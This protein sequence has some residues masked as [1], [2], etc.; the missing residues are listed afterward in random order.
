MPTPILHVK[1]KCGSK[2]FDLKALPDTGASR[3]ILAYDI[4][5]KF[6]LPLIEQTE[7]I[8]AANG[9]PLKCEG[10]VCLHLSFNNTDVILYPLVSSDLHYD[11][12]LSWHDLVLIGVIHSD[13]PYVKS[14]FT[15]VSA[16]YTLPDEL[17]PVLDEFQDVFGDFDGEVLKPMKGPPMSIQLRTDMPIHPIRVTTA[18]Q[19]PLHLREE[20][21]AIVEKCV[22]SGI[23]RKIDQVTP[24][25]SPAFFI[26]DPDRGTGKGKVRLV[27]DFSHLNRYVHRPIH[28]FPSS[29]DIIN[30]I[31]ADSRVFAKLDSLKGYWTIPLDEEAQLLTTILLPSGKYAHCRA[32]MGLNASNDEYCRRSDE[33]IHGIPGALK[34][35]DD[36]MLQAPNMTI[37]LERLRLYLQKCR[38]LGI[39]ISKPKLEIGPEIKFAGH[40]VSAEGVKPDPMKLSAIRDFPTPTDI[41]DLRSFLGLANQ[42]TIFHPDLAQ[43]T[44]LLR[45]LLRKNI[46]FQWLDE[47]EQCFRKVKEVLTSP[48]IVRYF[49]PKLPTELLTDASRLKGLGYA[50][51]QRDENNE[52]RLISCGSKSLTSAEK[53]YATIELECL[54]IVHAI[55]KCKHQLYGIDSFQV[56]TDHKPLVGIFQKRLDEVENNR[57]QRFREKLLDYNFVVAWT[58]GKLHLIADALSRNPVF[59]HEYDVNTNNSSSFAINIVSEDPCL[60]RLTMLAQQDDEYQK[61]IKLFKSHV[62]PKTLKSHP[63]KV[64]SSIWDDI[65]FNAD[66]GL[67]IYNDRRIIVPSNARDSILKILHLSHQGVNKTLM[68]IC[69]LYYW[70]SMSHNVHLLI[71]ACPQ[72]QMHRPAQPNQPLQPD[73]AIRPMQK[74]SC[75]LYHWDN[76]NYLIAVD[77]YSGYPFTSPLRQLHTT[78]VT[79]CLDNWFLVYGYPEVVKSDGGPQFRTEFAQYCEEH[80]MHHDISSAYHSQS[81]G[82]AEAGVRNVKHLIKKCSGFNQDFLTALQSFRNSVRPQDGFSPN[83]MF[84]GRRIRDALPCLPTSLDPVDQPSA[85][86]ARQAAVAKYKHAYDKHAHPLS[87]LAIG[88]YVLVQNP[89]SKLWDSTATVVGTRRHHRSYVLSYPDDSTNVRNRKFLKP[90]SGEFFHNA[91]HDVQRPESP[92]ATPHCSLRLRG[93]DPI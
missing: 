86:Q 16:S 27:T 74:V 90:V 80:F 5:Q 9:T 91:N 6:N 20:A 7:L 11:A 51:I 30:S 49:N 28:P 14:S 58:P 23:L 60:N 68:T 35:V 93:L 8:K 65:S 53:N 33:A 71:S 64:Y 2:S 63:A 83:E 66:L 24:W 67:L 32:P 21:E 72:C 89:I 62:H 78:A 10:T 75:D 1:V 79:Q 31:S 57:L 47:H 52:I 70:P 19:V 39:T 3:S 17:Q 22:S 36:T 34:I 45:G 69:K 87:H 61:C 84:L 12:I 41:T 85:M 48:A 76:K 55:R 25:I 18:R 50:L 54:A 46:Q 59:Q 40:I 92:A 29:Q 37:L 56:I 73:V 38:E 77:R 26:T 81:N 44:E 4:V 13:F 88:S 82:L 43:N 15:Q 42:L